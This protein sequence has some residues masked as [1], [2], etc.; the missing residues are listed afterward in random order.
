M[1]LFEKIILSL[2][3]LFWLVVIG[4]ILLVEKSFSWTGIVG[5][6][7]FLLLY[8]N[9]N[10]FIISKLQKFVESDWEVFKAK[11]KWANGWALL[12]FLFLL[13][14]LASIKGN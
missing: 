8:S 4:I 7:L 10:Y 14:L 6:V 11:L 9:A 13:A 1:K 2:I 5:L 12:V 3:I